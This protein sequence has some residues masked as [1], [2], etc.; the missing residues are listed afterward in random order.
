MKT[1]PMEPVGFRGGRCLMGRTYHMSR[2]SL[3][4]K[5]AITNRQV[6]K[7]WRAV[8]IGM[9]A[10]CGTIG[11]CLFRDNWVETGPGRTM[12]DLRTGIPTHTF[13]VQ[14][15]FGWSRSSQVHR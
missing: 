13:P 2:L 9:S 1:V 12:L 8:E 6:L 10:A 11:A 5:M 15:V 7:T 14:K 3:S 4:E